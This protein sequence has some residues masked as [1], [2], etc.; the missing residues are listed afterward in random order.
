[1]K[2]ENKMVKLTIG[3]LFLSIIC[4]T[5]TAMA[6]ETAGYP[7]AEKW[8]TDSHGGCKIL[9]KVGDS[10]KWNGECKNGKAYGRGELEELKQGT[11][12]F[13]YE[14]EMEN[15]QLNGAGVIIWASGARTEG[16][17]K[18]GQLAGYGK[19]AFD[20]S[21]WEGNHVNGKLHG[22]GIQV[23]KNGDRYEG[24]FASGLPSGKGILTW[25]EGGGYE[26]EFAGGKR[27]GQGT[28]TYKN[29][30]KFTGVFVEGKIAGEGVYTW[31]NGASERGAFTADGK[32]TRSATLQPGGGGLRAG[33]GCNEVLKRV[34]AA[35]GK[36]H[37]KTF[38]VFGWGE[39]DVW[40][41]E[42]AL[43][44]LGADQ[45][46]VY[47]RET[48]SRFDAEMDADCANGGAITF[49]KKSQQYS[50]RNGRDYVSKS[51]ARISLKEMR[52]SGSE[53]FGL[54]VLSGACHSSYSYQAWR[55][56]CSPSS[57]EIFCSGKECSGKPLD[58]LVKSGF[59]SSSQVPTGTG[60]RI[61][62][63]EQA[64]AQKKLEEETLRKRREEAAAAEAAAAAAAAAQR[65]KQA[66][67]E[68]RKEEERF[69][70][71]LK[72]GDSR[73][74]F[75]GAVAYEDKGDRGRAKSIYRAIMSRHAKSQ[76]ALQAATR[77]TKLADVEAI[78]SSNGRA[79][80][81]SYDA[82]ATVRRQAYEQ[83]VSNSNSCW[84]G[85]MGI[86]DY[87]ARANCERSCP[88]CLQ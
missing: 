39:T 76:E 14:G 74:M 71:L 27:H 63:I 43:A 65:E 51:V 2:R 47:E 20:G 70:A 19:H 28:L 5:S 66:A 6:E 10:A 16:Q 84:G 46:Y 52:I 64:L 81:A 69:S 67:E 9:P 58:S 57:Y 7:S 29:G 26:G 80:S 31:A 25:A 79:A 54:A 32:W 15:G 11:P 8:I 41:G 45:W 50:G 23:N 36:E 87:A 59:I 73:A 22:R 75:L 18:D 17:F 30:N 49:T 86:K 55:E 24:E 68:R 82:A 38:P 4:F 21:R 40:T 33:Q 12:M 35:F 13:R 61:S 88:V 72:G 60:E 44:L 42:K 83:C 62:K 48:V 3:L 1:M 34:I 37:G 78:E 77:L 56:W 85:C 53:F